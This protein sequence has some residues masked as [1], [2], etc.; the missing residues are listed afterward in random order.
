LEAN[1]LK[2]MKKKSIPH[3]FFAPLTGKPS[4]S[5]IGPHVAVRYGIP[6]LDVGIA[7]QSMHSARESLHVKDL[8]ALVRFIKE[9]YVQIS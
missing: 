1:I 8:E 9:L 5:T 4:G 2:I 6:T 3:Q 7:I